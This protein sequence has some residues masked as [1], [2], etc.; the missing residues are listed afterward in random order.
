M[1]IHDTLRSLVAGQT[2]AE[3]EAEAVFSSLLD[4]KL[5]QAQ[6]G[7]LLA[8]IQSR[9]PAVSEL[10]GAARVMRAHVTPVPVSPAAGQVLIDTCGTGGA[11]KMFNISTVAAIIA[12]AAGGAPDAPGVLVA[13][14]GNRSR[15]GRGSAEVLAAMGVNIDADPATQ[16]ACLERTGV[17]FCFA[18]HHHPA[19]KHAAAP[20]R[21]VG[22]PT[23]F[24]LLGPLTNPAGARRQL[25]GVYAKELV[26]PMAQTL[27]ALGAQRAIVAH[28]LDGLDELTTSA[29][30][31]LAHVESGVVRL[32]EVDAQALGIPRAHHDQMRIEG[33]EAAAETAREILEGKAGPRRN[34][35][36]FNAAAALL[37][38]GVVESLEHGIEASTDAIDSG[39]TARTLKSLCD[40]SHA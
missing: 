30:T 21:S 15:T 17:C 6:I 14:H 39:A 37:V 8:L 11:P 24:N 35:A 28:G 40:V 34:I 7:A 38:A 29:P 1:D 26:E 5:D 12:A 22:F 2:L 3:S 27:A 4:G 13:K 19:M 31:L 25:I 9:G 36:V 23:I 18:I 10:I 32:Q 16:A 20:R 33:L